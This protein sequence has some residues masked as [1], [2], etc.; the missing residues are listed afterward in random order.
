MRNKRKYIAATAAGIIG[1]IA[2]IAWA[3]QDLV[4]LDKFSQ[5]EMGMTQNQVQTLIGSPRRTWQTDIDNPRNPGRIWWSY[6]RR[7]TFAYCFV[8]FSTNGTVVGFNY[9]GNLPAH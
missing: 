7:F 4:P 8:A 6:D 2:L 1:I 9:E 5:I 3:A